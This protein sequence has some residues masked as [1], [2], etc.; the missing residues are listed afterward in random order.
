MACTEFVGRNAN[1]VQML[2]VWQVLR[3]RLSRE[4]A[5]DYAQDDGVWAGDGDRFRHA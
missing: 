4:A 2:A 3:L 5:K 1:V